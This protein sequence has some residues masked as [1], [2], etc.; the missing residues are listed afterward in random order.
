[1]KLYIIRHG[2]S[3]NNAIEDQ[4]DRVKDPALT[5]LG[6]SQAEN[7]AEH[8]ATGFDPE[9]FVGASVEATSADNRHHYNIKQLYC[10]AM[11]RTL[12]TAKP[13]GQMLGLKPEVWLDIHEV[14][15]IFLEQGDGRGPVGYPGKNRSQILA[16]FPD[17]ILPAEIT[18]DGWWR[19]EQGR[20]DYPT[21]Q[22]RALKVA[23]TLRQWAADGED[24]EIAMVSHGGFVDSLLKALTNQ[25]PGRHLFYHHYNTGI[26]RVDF[27]SDGR[28]DV[29]HL[30]RFDHLPPEL[31]S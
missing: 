14:G 7:V 26:T 15:G 13:I 28:V 5:G 18:D 6:Q 30:N 31:I 16:E 22:G 2:Q 21:C 23:Y 8:L 1:M 24:G 9:Y 11:Y 19:P 27:R 20:E 12:L 10:S 29:R 17:Y 25:L 4:R 3:T